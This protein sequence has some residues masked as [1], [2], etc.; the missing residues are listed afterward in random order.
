[1]KS[2][3]E[4]IKSVALPKEH[5]GWGLFFEPAVIGLLVKPSAAGGFLLLA[6]L[7]AFLLNQPLRIFFQD[8][9]SGQAYPHTPMVQRFVLGY[10]LTALVF[11]VLAVR[12][13]ENSF[14]LPCLLA[15]PLFGIHFYFALRRQSRQIA[16]EL[17]GAIAV[18]AIAPMILAAGGAGIQ[19]TYLIWFL[20]I[21]RSVSSIFYVRYKLK[22]SRG[23]PA[24]K[25]GAAL[26][27]LGFFLCFL[28]AAVLRLIPWLAFCGF[29]MLAGRM[30]RGLSGTSLKTLRPQTVGF[31]EMASGILNSLLIIAG[32]LWNF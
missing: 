23:L 24:S 27:G 8:R 25:K 30:A 18:A 20:L 21:G 19:T 29:A 1:M 13:T 9:L 16:A 32:Y 12:M 15:A 5:G 3:A 28:L 31:Q 4:R 10:G 14:W 11:F 26:I 22:S 6:G 17:L 7:A 2:E